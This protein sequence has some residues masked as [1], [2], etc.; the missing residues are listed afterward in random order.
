MSACGPMDSRWLCLQA[1]IYTRAKW[2]FVP[3]FLV[4]PRYPTYCENWIQ[5]ACGTPSIFQ[6]IACFETRP[7]QSLGRGRLLSRLVHWC[8]R[9]GDAVRSLFVAKKPFSMAALHACVRYG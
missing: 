5:T 2:L 3:A 4:W 9:P 7:L 1:S 6:I 8:A